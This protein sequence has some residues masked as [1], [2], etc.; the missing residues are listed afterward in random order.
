MVVLARAKQASKKFKGDEKMPISKL[1]LVCVL[2]FVLVSIF[3]SCLV[4]MKVCFFFL[5]IWFIGFSGCV[6]S[7]RLLMR[8]VGVSQM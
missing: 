6:L 5:L 1:H 7:N 4:G 8:I 2:P 3:F